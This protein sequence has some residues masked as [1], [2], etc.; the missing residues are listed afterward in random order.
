M[1]KSFLHPRWFLFRVYKAERALKW[2]PSWEVRHLEAMNSIPPRN[3]GLVYFFHELQ[4]L[5]KRVESLSQPDQER[6]AEI[7]AYKC[8]EII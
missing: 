7:F 8:D 4:A 6:V 5:T 1:P 3:V 2:R